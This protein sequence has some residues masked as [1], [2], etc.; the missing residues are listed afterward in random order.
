PSLQENPMPSEPMLRRLAQVAVNVHDLARATAWYRDAL[1]LRHLFS[2]GSMAFFDIG[3]TR[4]MLALPETEEFDHPASILYYD[5]ADIAS[6]HRTLVERGVRCE[7]EP[8]VVARLPASDL[9]M[10]E[11]RDSEGNVLA[12]QSEVA[13]H[14]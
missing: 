9:W 10:A 7:G 14:A 12:L 6:A 11:F 4:L 1:G 5:V 13:R 3:G 2:A 8:H